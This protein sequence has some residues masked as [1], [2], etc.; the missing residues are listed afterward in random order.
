[1]N[2][3]CDIVIM[4]MG[5]FAAETLGVPSNATQIIAPLGE[6]TFCIPIV[7]PMRFMDESEAPGMTGWED[8]SIALQS[9]ACMLGGKSYR[10]SAGYGR[11]ANAFVWRL[12]EEE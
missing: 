1:M 12:E 10:I 2:Q 3:A 9:Y 6:Q 8:E 4:K 5:M 11:R 7:L